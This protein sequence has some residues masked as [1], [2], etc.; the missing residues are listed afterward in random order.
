MY[1]G[2]SE[3]TDGAATVISDA[4][5]QFIG[6]INELVKNGQLTGHICINLVR[7]SIHTY[8]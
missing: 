6:K 7:P 2:F 4:K 3:V 5:T 8:K 1:S